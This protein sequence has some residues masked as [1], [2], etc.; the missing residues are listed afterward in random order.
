MSKNKKNAKRGNVRDPTQANLRSTIT[1]QSQGV[2]VPAGYTR[3]LDSPEIGACIDR[4]VSLVAALPIYLM[5]NSELGDVREHNEMSRLVDVSP[6]RHGSRRDW[7]SWVLTTLLGEGDGNAICLI[8]TEQGRPVELMPMPGASLEALDG[9]LDYR[10]YWRGGTYDPADCLH[11]RLFSD[12][13]SPWRGRGYRVKSQDIAD[14]LA[15]ASATKTEYLRSEYKPPLIISVDTDSDLSDESRRERLEDAYLKRPSGKPWI[16]P[17]GLIKIDSV[18]PMSLSDLAIADTISLDRRSAA[19]IYGLPAFLVGEG[20]YNEQE[21]QAFVR[22]PIKY[23][24]EGIQQEL[25]CKLLMNPREY[26]KFGVRRLYNY[27]AAAVTSIMLSMA[28][29]GMADGNEV[30]AE[31]DLPPREGLD[32][33]RALENYIPADMAGE[34]KKLRPNDEPEEETEES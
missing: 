23:I 30:R 9:G 34:Q 15:Q 14:S 27:D 7:M 32:E 18:K 8:R 11:F 12:P 6:W 3:L 28:A 10:I 13:A 17:G 31:L 24:C 26:Y 21:Y 5:R 16:I 19:A 22:G 2:V 33:L 4:I 29:Q 1:L 20:S 25:T